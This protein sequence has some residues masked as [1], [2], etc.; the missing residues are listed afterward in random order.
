MI[1]N[2]NIKDQPSQKM[3]KIAPKLFWQKGKN[4]CELTS[5]KLQ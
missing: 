5:N 3:V 4:F 1:R 2:G